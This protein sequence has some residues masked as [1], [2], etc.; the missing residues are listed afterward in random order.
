MY[1]I[2][3][4]E[5]LLVLIDKKDKEFYTPQNDYQM[6][7]PYHGNRRLL[8]NYVDMLEK[9]PTQEFIAIYSDDLPGLFADFKHNFKLIEAAGGFVFNAESK[10]LAIFRRGFW[11]LP[12]GKIDEGEDPPTTAIREVREETGLQ[13]LEIGD[14]ITHTWHT[15]RIKKKKRIL[16]KT[17]WYRMSTSEEKLTPQ[18]EEDIEKAV[19]MKPEELLAKGKLLYSSIREALL[20]RKGD[21][22]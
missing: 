4:N 1:K 15:Y 14:F 19:W 18:A 22:E 7:V 20:N 3:I 11:D 6:L 8:L 17:Y 5:K 9:S 21:D 10:I 13:E 12:K 16:K 2:Y